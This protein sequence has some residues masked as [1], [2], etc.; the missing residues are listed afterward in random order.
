MRASYGV[1]FLIF[2]IFTLTSASAQSICTDS[3]YEAGGFTLSS[4]DICHT[5]KPAIQNTGE[6]ENPK[7][8]YNYRG[9]SYEEVLALGGD[10][11]DFSS[12]TKPGLYQVIQVGKKGGKESVACQEIKVRNANTA[13]F[14]YTFCTGPNRR[15][16]VIIPDHPLNKQFS[17]FRIELDN[18][19]YDVSQTNIPYPFEVAGNSR[20]SLKVTGLGGG[21]TC[22]S[23][24]SITWVEPYD[25]TGRNFDYYPEIK[26]LKILDNKRTQVRIQG[27]YTESYNLYRYESG[28]PPVG[29]QPFKVNLKHDEPVD[30][31][32]TDPARVYCYFIQ[33]ATAANCG[34]FSLRSADICSVPLSTPLPP[35]TTSNHLAWTVAPTANYRKGELQ[36]ISNG[37]GSPSIDVTSRRTYQDN[38]GDC[39]Q[40]I[41]Y[42][43][44]VTYSGNNS[45]A[46]FSG[47][48]LSNQVCVDHRLDLTDY[49][50]DAYVTTEEMK[51]RVYFDPAVSSTYAPDRWELFKHDGT[52]Y[53]LVETLPG[54]ASDF[55]IP[56]P[57]A[58]PTQEEKYMIRYVDE[59][60]NIS[61]FSPE[62][63]SIYLSHNE[64]NLHWTGGNPFADDAVARYEII[65]YDAENPN[66]VLGTEQVNGAQL[67]QAVNTSSFSNLG[68][69]RIK[70]ESAD[71]R[72]SYSDYLKFTVK[73]SLYLPTAFSPNSDDHNDT[74]KPTGNLGGIKN[75]KM[76]IFSSNGQK[77][78]D[79]T[80]PHEGWN[81]LLPNGNKALFGNYLYRVQAEMTNEQVID[82][83]G[84]F[85]LLY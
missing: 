82:K 71:G 37:S 53:S 56:D 40:K 50:G 19:P 11:L 30:F 85:V 78:A 48:S 7:Y 27:Q 51:N 55:V 21:K 24:P 61:G 35:V 1:A 44:K 64:N 9:E 47:T 84:S 5:E 28:Q 81:G 25:P 65:Y 68:T 23:D 6:V 31:D 72:E 33:P 83:N 49:P 57:V 36:K 74:F 79:I 63:T 45:G 38:H 2:F 39:S 32:L 80:N 16:E 41:C 10:E 52:D 3:R 58:P 62:L 66:I 14:S 60:E 43:I 26:E 12:V 59:C 46:N 15:I 29:L 76:E 18:V 22:P 20:H 8:Y 75:F 4:T 54:N 77:V 70:A 13:V 67:S 34:L 42:R 69:F 73:G 17:S